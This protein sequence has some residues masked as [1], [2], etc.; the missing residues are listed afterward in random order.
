MFCRL[1]TTQS[2]G[3]HFKFLCSVAAR[4]GQ[5]VA[6][7]CIY[8]YIY[9]LRP[10]NLNPPKSHEAQHPDKDTNGLGADIFQGANVNSLTVVAK[11]VP[12]VDTLH[13][14]LA[15]LTAPSGTGQEQG[16]KCIFD[17]PM[18]PIL[19]LNAGGRRN[20]T[21]PKGMSLPRNGKD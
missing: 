11:P 15:E 7:Q 17:I 20:I 2:L 18:A 13:V 12:E 14:E 16:Q 21:S 3:R 9:N 4:R 10:R 5:R 8:I 6:K 1:V 19:S